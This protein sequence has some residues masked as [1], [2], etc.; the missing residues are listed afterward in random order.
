MSYSRF[1]LSSEKAEEILEKGIKRIHF[2]GALGAGMLPLAK[3]CRHLGYDISG[4]DARVGKSD[5]SIE[6]SAGDDIGEASR[7][8]FRLFDG[9]SNPFITPITP[10][11]H[12]LLCEVDLLV[13]SFA[14]PEDAPEI[15]D[16]VAR[17]IPIVSRAELLGALMTRYKRRVG[18]CGSHGK[19]TTTALVDKM[20]C[21][22]G[23]SHITVSGATLFDGLDIRIEPSD[24]FVYEACEYRDAFL[25]FHPTLQ[26]ITSIELDHTDYFADIDAIRRSFLLAANKAES[27]VVLNAD[28]SG[29]AEFAATLSAP[30]VTYGRAESADYRYAIDEKGREGYKFRILRRGEPFLNLQTPL[31][32]EYNVANITAAVAAADMLGVDSDAIARAVAEFG[33]I[34]RRMSYLARLGDTDIFYDYAHHP[35]EIAAAIAAVRDRYD[36]CAVIFKPH[37][38]SRTKALWSEFIRAFDRSDA[39][40]LLDIYPAREAEIDGVTSENLARDMGYGAFYTNEEGAIRH[41]LDGKYPAVIIMGAGDMSALVDMIK[42][43]DTNLNN[44][45]YLHRKEEY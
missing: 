14:I 30:V 1:F 2:V 36:S 20:L 24:T 22:G 31:V 41:I 27:G 7:G 32:G 44:K 29:S 26:I 34:E 6:L 9:G 4:S 17:R 13:A 10:H 28:F 8:A 5:F 15:V 43:C 11:A 12:G 19:S 38:Y 37:T 21:T 18:I 25:R 3:L 35:T 45:E 16:A 42:K 39:T 33:G 40:I 23:V